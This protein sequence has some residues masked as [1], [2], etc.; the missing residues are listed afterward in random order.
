[1]NAKVLLA[2]FK[3]NFVSYFA[4][5]TGYLFICV[6]VL[7]STVAAFWPNEFFNTNLA[8]LS[9][10]N[11]WFPFIMLVF[12]PAITMAVWADER[13]QGTDE[14][15]LTLPAG[16]FDIVLGKYL[17]SMAIYTVALMFSLASNV[18]VLAWLGQPDLG[19]FIGT[20]IGYWLV[21]LAM[22]AIGMVASYL[23]GNL[24]VAYI[25]GA[26]FNVPLVFAVYADSILNQ[27]YARAVRQWSIGERFADFGRGIISLSGVLYFLGIVVVMLYLSMVLISRR[28]WQ[29]GRFSYLMGGHY[30]ARTAALAVAVLSAVLIFQNHDLRLDVTSERL[31]SLSPETAK[32]LKGL[33]IERPVKIEAFVS[34]EVPEAYIQTRLDLLS[35]LR[36]LEARGGGKV[37]VRV[38]PTER[39]S[40]QAMRAEKRYDILPKR[41]TAINRGT[42]SEDHIFMG[43]A[44]TSGLEKVI[45]PFVDRGIP[46]EYELVRSIT[47]V[48]Q[49]ARKKIGVVKTDAQLYGSFDMQSMSARDNWPIID[50]LQ[51]QYEVVEVDPA[52][53]ITERYDALLAVQPSSLGPQ[54]M[55]NFIA[56]VKSG[57]PTAVFEDPFPVF[58]GRV[59]GTSAP[60]QMPGGMNMMMMGGGQP[61]E[62]GNVAALWN[63]LGIDFSG[64]QIVW[65]DYNPYPKLSHL[66]EE[67]V[68]VDTTLRDSDPFNDQNPVSSRLQHMLFPFPGSVA[69][70]NASSFQFTPLVRT[71]DATGTVAFN[72]VVQMSPFGA[73]GGLNPQRKQIP[74]GMS[75]V[76]AAHIKGKIP[77]A[78][79][80]ADENAA[81]GTT[82]DEKSDKP[83]STTQPSELNV[84]VVA[85]IDMLHEEFFRLREQGNIPEAGISF[86]F[87]NVTFV[88]NVL[89]NLAGDTRFIELRKRRPQHRTL[90]RIEAQTENARK[91]TAKTRQDLLD[92]FDKVKEEEERSLREYVDN[93]QKDMQKNKLPSQEILIR[94]AMVQQDRERRMQTK[95]DQ[96]QQERDK[97][98]NEIETALNL[99]IRS[100]QDTYKMWAVLLPPIP[101]LVV[102]GIVFFTRRRQERQGVARSRLRS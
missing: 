22:L 52:Q 67:F 30:A 83:A 73:M 8:N 64:D 65:Q 100:L 11:K 93:L 19:L 54:E 29:T 33:N 68:F 38:N 32:I 40:E 87:D 14:L 28:H 17:S 31:S 85:D 46:V 2:V 6:F 13:R 79:N 58:A 10:L 5:P 72:D 27:E 81:T 56:A 71:G 7:L 102:A 82:P 99:R 43:V 60:R 45:L 39:F 80:M 42:L 69:K 59:P 20:Y 90:T 88:L 76:L 23:T 51:K 92:K 1:M 15:L 75:F 4:N 86:D 34:P 84:I 9:Q 98:I 35:M 25:L 41:V 97:E 44:F 48:T 24:T 61:P 70:L 57:Q 63:T 53:P 89:D 37:Q 94:V 96:L 16:D 55:D 101:P 77:T 18:L 3:R 26:A 78:M 36:E 66:P 49:Q 12:I 74:A 91:Q 50:E 21:G 47:T 62:K 95:I